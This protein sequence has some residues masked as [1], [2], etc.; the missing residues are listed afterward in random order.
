VRAIVA[1]VPSWSRTPLAVLVAALLGAGTACTS[2]HVATPEHSASPRNSTSSATSL[3]KITR[4]VQPPTP[5]NIS[6]TVKPGKAKVLSP[7]TMAAAALFGNGVIAKVVTHQSIRVKATMPHEI[8][9]PAAAIKIRISNGST[10]TVDLDNAVVTAKDAAGTPLVE[11]NS[12]P[13]APLSGSIAVGKDATGVYVFGLPAS[14][15]NPLT[16]NF[17]YSTAV[18]VAI[19]VGGVQ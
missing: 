16:V 17:S 3:P 18:P 8:S 10:G 9:G 5:G 4:P 6:Q 13:S 11:M 14:Y 2:S 19:F 15:H 1:R 12:S 7:V